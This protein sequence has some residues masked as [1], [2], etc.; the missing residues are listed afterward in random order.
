L[1]AAFSWRLNPVREPLAQA[2]Y[3]IFYVP[4]SVLGLLGFFLGRCNRG[5][6][7][8]GMLFIAFMAVT[9]VFWAHTSH[10]SYLDVY[11]IVL[12]AS[13]IDRSLAWVEKRKNK[14]P[15]GLATAAAI[16]LQ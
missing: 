5:V 2:S 4:I 7:L 6:I 13:V 15:A 8:I 14:G 9:A 3:A 11:L 16:Q 12:A 10:R 1:E